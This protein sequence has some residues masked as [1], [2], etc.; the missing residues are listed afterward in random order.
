[1]RDRNALRRFP[2]LWQLNARTT[3][4]RIGDSATLA[5]LD[6]AQLDALV[7]SGVDWLYLLGV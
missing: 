2:V 3:V 7:P 4:H 5:D 6:D 1:M